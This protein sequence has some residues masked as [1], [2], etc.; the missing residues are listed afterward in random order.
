MGQFAYAKHRASPTTKTNDSTNNNCT[1]PASVDVN[2]AR[3]GFGGVVIA[4]RTMVD[5]EQAASSTQFPWPE[6]RQDQ[7][8]P[9]SFEL[10]IEILFAV[11]L[12][13]GLIFAWQLD[14]CL[15]SWSRISLAR[16]AGCKLFSM[17]FQA[18]ARTESVSIVWFGCRGHDDVATNGGYNPGKRAGRRFGCPPVVA[19][20]RSESI[21]FWARFACERA[22]GEGAGRASRR[23][24]EAQPD[25]SRGLIL[26]AKVPFDLATIIAT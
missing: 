15:S 7:T 25:E 24:D 23:V 11:C 14:D 6:T 10:A 1:Q 3:G 4:R 12:V 17:N 16:S 13:F 22:G 5:D 9:G 20:G 19:T 2:G 21:W 26:A 8:S 18:S